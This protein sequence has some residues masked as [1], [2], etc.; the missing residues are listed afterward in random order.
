VNPLGIAVGVVIYYLMVFARRARTKKFG[1]RSTNYGMSWGW[2]KQQTMGV[3]MS[4]KFKIPKTLGACVDKLYRLRGEK[5]EA[6][7]K[8]KMLE[9]QINAVKAHLIEELPRA[10]AN[11][12]SGK[13]AKGELTKKKVGTVK[14]WDRFYAYIRRHKAH[15]LMQRRVSNTALNE[16]WE[17]GKK[18]PGV[19]PFTVIDVS[20]T[21]KR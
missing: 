14:N 21:K 13:V 16:V 17:G 19:E 7:K 3:V 2:P 12:I 15:H 1:K 11:G 8:V 10:D 4:P 5:S 6:T 18:V 9:E 20:C